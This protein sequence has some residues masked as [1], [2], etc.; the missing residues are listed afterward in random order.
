MVRSIKIIPV[1]LLCWGVLV[2]CHQ[3][4]PSSTHSTANKQ[5]KSNTYSALKINYDTFYMP[6]NSKNKLYLPVDDKSMSG[7]PN[8]L[9]SYNLS[10][11]KE[12]TIFHSQIKDANV[13]GV[14]ANEK[15][16]LWIDTDSFGT[17]SVLY[18]KNLINNQQ[19]N[20][21]TTKKILDPF[22]YDHYVSWMDID[23]E[24]G[25]GTIVLYDLETNTK[26]Q[27]ATLESYNTY[28]TTIH[29]NNNKLVYSNSN[30]EQTTVYTY[31]LKNEQVNT[32]E[33]PQKYIMKPRIVGNKI[34]YTSFSSPEKQFPESYYILDMESK[35]V[36][37]FLQDDITGEQS[38]SI[39]L[40]SASKDYMIFQT[41]DQKIF[42]YHINNNE[43]KKTKL[44]ISNMFKVRMSENRD[45]TVI[46]DNPNASKKSDLQFIK[47]IP[48]NELKNKFQ[49]N[50]SQYFN[51]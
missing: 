1:L 6:S 13:Q 5:D 41:T 20:I 43:Y 40:V 7:M 18:V 9:I 47:L 48:Y 32:Y 29:M 42:A 31:N 19:S 3:T 26:K 4:S 50:R 12:E 39:G 30:G 14:Q 33:I 45:V 15:W 17:N 27:I 36:V 51:Y 44:E 37:P 2:S 16:L 8:K 28:S 35:N 49:N 21:Y 24:N 34:F 22:L 23:D 11:K 38:N 25:I 46:C 10:N